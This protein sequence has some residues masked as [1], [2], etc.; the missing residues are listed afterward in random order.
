MGRQCA[1]IVLAAA[2]LVIAGL[3]P[4]TPARAATTEIGVTLTTSNLSLAL[5]PQPSIALGPVSSGSVNL[6]V[7]DATAYQ[8]IDGFG[9]AF[10][11]TSDY[12][13]EDALSAATRDQV[14]NALF[15]PTTGIGL[16]LNRVPM[17][18]SD[19]TATPV[20]DPS[21]YSYD[22]N[23]GVADPTLANFS[24]AHD[25]AYTVPIIEQAAALNPSMKLIATEW[26]RRPG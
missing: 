4:G 2:G 20:S 8:T 7:N 22:D 17:G 15:S 9:A 21:T 5:T 11:D 3:A 26:A 19:Y 14:M 1:V 24:I 6:T 10:T 18:S 12:L 16:S 13:L 25:E 23:G